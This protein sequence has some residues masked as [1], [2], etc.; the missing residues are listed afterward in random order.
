MS[1]TYTTAKGVQLAVGQLYT[2]IYRDSLR[3][4]AVVEIGAPRTDFQDRIC[5]EVV[6]RVVVR[7]GARV[8]SARLQRMDAERLADPKLYQ[9]VEDAALAKWVRS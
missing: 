9:L 8:T 6:Y 4:L 7:D 3:V 1:K 2:D 5:C